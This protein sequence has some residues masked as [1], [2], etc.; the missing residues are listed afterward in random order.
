MASARASAGSRGSLPRAWNGLA[1]GA[2]VSWKCDSVELSLTSETFVRATGRGAGLACAA[3]ALELPANSVADPIA[4]TA[5]SPSNVRSKLVKRINF[6]DETDKD[7]GRT[8][9][10]PAPV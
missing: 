10:Q 1:C 9:V 7:A 8:E 6:V 4:T 3:A 2:R 5:K